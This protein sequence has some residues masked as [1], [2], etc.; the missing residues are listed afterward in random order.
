[1]LDVPVVLI[2]FNRPDKIKRTLDA[3]RVVAPTRLFLLVDAP[4][5][6]RS[7]DAERCAEVRRELEAIDWPCTVER[8]YAETN[9]GCE[10]NIE[11][12][13]DWVFSTVDRAIIL[14][15]DCRPD[16]TFFRYCDELLE[17]Y[18]DDE[19]VWQ[20]AGNSYTV[21][22]KFFGGHSY[23][24]AGFASVWGWATWSRAWQA[25]RAVFTRSHST[26]GSFNTMPPERT[27][28]AVMPTG[29]LQTSAGHRYFTDVAAA[30]DGNVFSWD[31]HWWVTMLTHGGLAISP[32]VNLVENIG[33][34]E[35]ATYTRTDREQPR[36]VPM[37][38][39]L[40]HPES[41]ANNAAVAREIELET[42]RSGGR[43]ARSLVRL[44]GD[45]WLRKLARRASTSSTLRRV[46]RATAALGAR[47]RRNPA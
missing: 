20:I 8:R 32:A 9:L 41:V 47:L 26:A 46:L 14:E 37:A 24:F 28:P 13:L 21:P 18:A 1:M 12:G 2:A 34:G 42:T 30:T 31:S 17:R 16:P 23:A 38:F 40:Q 3:V 43:L 33:F 39:P 6:G 29:A 22:E 11:T 15:D 4:R 45:G 36:A 35:D 7:D 27:E 10:A 44:L 19:R 25:H 5:E